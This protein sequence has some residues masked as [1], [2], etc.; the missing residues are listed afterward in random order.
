M[1]WESF[2]ESVLAE[3]DVNVHRETIKALLL[4]K[5]KG[6]VEEYKREFL[7]LVYQIKLYEPAV[8]DTFLVTRFILGLKE[9][10]QGAVEI[11]FLVTIAA[12]AAFAT[13]QEAT[14]ARHK[15]SKFQY[16]TALNKSDPKAAT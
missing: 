7:Q 15:T 13:V 1:D 11:Q 4:L 5:Q 10:V 2:R 14:L 9:E 6:N 16:K 3:F 12:A 8:S